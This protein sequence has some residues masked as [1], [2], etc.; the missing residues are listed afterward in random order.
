MSGTLS[1]GDAQNVW[2]AGSGGQI[3]KGTPKYPVSVSDHASFDFSISS[4][5]FI[6]GIRIESPDSYQG[7]QLKVYSY[8]GQLM[9]SA[10]IEELQ[11][12]YELE[13]LDFLKSGVYFVNLNTLDRKLN[14]TKKIVRISIKRF[15]FHT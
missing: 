11:E 12:S 4:N 7:V 3:F 15:Y 13:G 8:S 14:S 9:K 1:A 5:P 2:I 6:S 10:Y